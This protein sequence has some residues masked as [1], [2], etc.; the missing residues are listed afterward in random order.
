MM[1]AT[2]EMPVDDRPRVLVVDDDRLILAT[3]SEGL[4]Q[5]GYD[6]MEA[7]S[8]EEGMTLARDGN[9]D[10]AILDMRMPG[11]SGL[12]VARWLQIHTD[13]PYLFLS[14]YGDENTVADA[15]NEGAMGY[16]VKPLDVLQVIPAL[17]AALARSRELRRLVDNEANLEQA[18][19]QGRQISMA[20]GLLMERYRLTEREAFERLRGHAR[21][22]RI[23]VSDLAAQLLN[24]S[25]ALNALKGDQTPRRPRR[26]G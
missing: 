11:L 10:I 16:L 25:D 24:A 7:E 18:L 23:K 5:A 13:T 6:V 9:P 17:E 26:G 15:V 4:K 1:M 22:E 12:E 14:A 19:Q 2:T 3:L 20:V 21:S 8:G